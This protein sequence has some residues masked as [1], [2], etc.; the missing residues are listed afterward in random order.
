[1]TATGLRVR[2]ETFGDSRWFG[3]VALALSILLLGSNW[4]VMKIALRTATP[5]CLTSV[6]LL[7][8]GV[9]YLVLLG[10]QGRLIWPPRREWRMI[11]VLGVFQ[12]ALMTGLIMVGVGIVGAGRSA[13]LAYTTPIWVMPGAALLFNERISRLQLAGLAFGVAGVVVLFNPAAFDWTDSRTIAGNACVLGGALAWSVALLTTRGHTWRMTPLQTM[14]YQ[15]LLGGLLL[16]PV[17]MVTEGVLPRGDT[18]AAF[19]LAVAYIGGGATFVAYWM[20]VEAARRMPAGRMSLAQLSTP[21]I[22]VG[23]SA[24]WV[25]EAPSVDNLLGLALILAGVG[26]SAIRQRDR[27]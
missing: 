9:L 6:R 8:A 13:I 1:M 4:P 2:A 10:A 25:G 27:A 12:S 19:V 20:V 23:A 24:R 16:L 15:T 21:V 18:S 17:A 26:L 3:P 7:M 5:L 11:V 14:P 22:G